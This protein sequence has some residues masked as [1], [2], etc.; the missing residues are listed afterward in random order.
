M[1]RLLFRVLLLVILGGAF[2]ASELLLNHWQVTAGKP[3]RFRFVIPAAQEL[4]KNHSAA[5]DP[6]VKGVQLAGFF[7]DW[8]LT[9]PEFR[10]REVTAGVFEKE[11]VLPPGNSQYKYVVLLDGPVK[12]K[13]T[14]RTVTEIWLEDPAASSYADD[15]FGGR[16]AVVSIPDAGL[17][18]PFTRSAAAILFLTLTALVILELLAGVIVKMRLHIRTKIAAA[19]FL[20]LLAMGLIWV[21]SAETIGLS[22]ARE[23][24]IGEMQMAHL[25]LLAQG[26]DPGALDNAAG[27]EGF[28]QALE[29]LMK[30][31]VP[32]IEKRNISPR[33]SLLSGLY[34]FSVSGSLMAGAD[35]PA[36]GLALTAEAATNGFGSV[37]EYL[38][39]GLFA[40]LLKEA[41]AMP[42]PVYWGRTPSKYQA[43]R[44]A[45][46]KAALGFFNSDLVLKPIWHGQR[47]TGFYGARIHTELPGSDIALL[48]FISLSIIVLVF[49]VGIV[50]LFRVG[51]GIESRVQALSSLAGSL[52][53]GTAVPGK[54]V[55]DELEDL[56]VNIDRMRVCL[57]HSEQNLKLVNLLTTK[58]QT[59]RHVDDVYNVFL[60]FVT[61]NFGLSYNRAALFLHENG[62]LAGRT[63]IGCL[64]AEEV[65]R[66]FGSLA[67]YSRLQ[68]DINSFI[69]NTGSFMNKLDSTFNT[70]VR[71]IAVLPDDDSLLWEAFYIRKPV[72]IRTGDTGH[73]E[74]DS[75]IRRRLNLEEFAL[76][77]VFMGREVVGV[78]LVDNPFD[79]KPITADSISELE[80][81]LK[82]LGVSLESVFT[83]EN[84]EG[85]IE[86]LQGELDAAN[87]LAVREKERADGYLRELHGKTQ[88]HREDRGYLESAAQTLRALQEPR[89]KR[90]LPGW[91]GRE[92]SVL[93]RPDSLGLYPAYALSLKRKNGHYRL[94]F[95]ESGKNG[96]A[97][98][99]L[100]EFA[101]SAAQAIQEKDPAPGYFLEE[102]NREMTRFFHL[103]G[104][105]LGAHII[106]FDPGSRMMIYS[107]AGERYLWKYR[108]GDTK[109]L[110][111]R[112]KVLGDSEEVRYFEEKEE[113][114]PG[115]KVFITNRFTS[116]LDIDQV[117]SFMK[118]H[119]KMSVESTV[120]AFIESRTVK[121]S[122]ESDG[123]GFL[124]IG[125]GA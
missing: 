63:A 50:V 40:A 124:V 1:K 10:M 35:A 29:N 72:L 119:D 107:A 13:K 33:Q 7:S 8:S 60:T 83:R 68:I 57:E 31:A 3:V 45:A 105:Y 110:V 101:H 123:S 96:L 100:L 118:E 70:A 73:R 27:R 66:T 115:G 92:Y 125:F 9:S 94:I 104:V 30:N 15:G 46:E 58:M 44:K 28:R 56:S 51:D 74:T 62:R 37:T 34:V 21:R 59:M 5:E 53:A 80:T 69:E 52:A 20:L 95:L 26:A 103:A 76:F 6:R 116:E 81:F 108:S 43:T 113:L 91:D 79:K 122:P 54:T 120:A 114:E 39:K 12:D 16:N 23:S 67:D 88:D 111:K 24:I 99:L 112:G 90:N 89:I 22:I 84:L 87:A 38:E 93:A 4:F 32:R 25:S 65:V 49:I 85:R 47:L 71:G 75:I 17:I 18:R 14:G 41:S 36:A 121:N 11:L 77:P 64:D 97:S 109:V 19:F 117:H 82:E 42:A 78:L 2:A 55:K 106:D 61:A 48:V 98:P 86:K 102:L